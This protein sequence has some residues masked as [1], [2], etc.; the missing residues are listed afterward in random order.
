MIFSD[1]LSSFARAKLAAACAS[2]ADISSVSR[3]NRFTAQTESSKCRFPRLCL[4][5]AIIFPHTKWLPKIT[6]YHD[7]AALSM[8][9]QDSTDRVVWRLTPSR[10]G[11]LGA[12]AVAVIPTFATFSLLFFFSFSFSPLFQY[13]EK[14]RVSISAAGWN[15]PTL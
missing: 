1:F 3:A 11:W 8:S 7:T 6:D 10:A 12:V 2:V 9:G 4:A 14:R 13:L 15:A 5:A